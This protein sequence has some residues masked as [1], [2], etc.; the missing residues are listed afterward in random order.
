M[1]A[2]KNVFLHFLLDIIFFSHPKK[3]LF[4][5]FTVEMLKKKKLL[6]FSLMCIKFI[7]QM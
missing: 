4:L 3:A 7:E 5:S 2:F 6:D 1:L